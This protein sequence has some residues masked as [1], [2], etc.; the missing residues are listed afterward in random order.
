MLEG[1][2]EMQTLVTKANGR[3]EADGDQQYHKIEYGVERHLHT[4]EPWSRGVRHEEDSQRF[5]IR[6]FWI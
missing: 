2:L 1:F 5:T 4:P 6:K 3:I